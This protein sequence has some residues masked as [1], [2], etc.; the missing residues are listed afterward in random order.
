MHFLLRFVPK[1]HLSWCVGKLARCKLPYGLSQELINWFAKRYSV[2]VDEAEFPLA[3]YS[4]LAEF[5]TRRLKPGIRS[6]GLGVISPVD[7]TVVEHGVLEGS[8]IMQAKGKF[9]QVGE[10][11]GDNTLAK[12]FVDGYFITIYLAPGDYHRIHSPVTGKIVRAVYVEGNL[13]PVNGKSVQQI[14]NLFSINERITS[15]IESEFG[16]VAVVKVGATNVGEISVCYDTLVANQR[17][18]LIQK[19]RRSESRTYYDGIS[20][21]R[22]D[23]LGI[24]QMGSTVILLF[25]KNRFVPRNGLGGKVK[26]GE[27]L[28]Q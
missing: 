16:T 4:T 11:L 10:L 3:G 23:E 19:P 21:Q 28:N 6:I 9:Y 8:R 5:F 26:M 7:G 24:F 20:I 2:H 1:N 12:Q 18:R 15:V 22:G 25:E 27:Q 17:P 13:W 14:T